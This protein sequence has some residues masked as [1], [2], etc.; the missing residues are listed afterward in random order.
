MRTAPGLA[1]AA[2]MIRHDI[3]CGGYPAAVVEA[4][5]ATADDLADLADTQEPGAVQTMADHLR[6]QE[7]AARWDAHAAGLRVATA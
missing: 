4:L 6:R 7:A 1:L 5:A 3:T 2:L